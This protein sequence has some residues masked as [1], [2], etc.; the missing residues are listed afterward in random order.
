MR[1]PDWGAG[2]RNFTSLY[3]EPLSEPAI[4]E[5]LAGLV[6]GLPEPTI[7][8]VVARADGIP[9]YAVEIVRMLLAEGRVRE[10]GG[11]Y[12]PTGDIIRVLHPGDAHRA[13]RVAARR[14]GAGGPRPGPG[15][16][17]ARAELHARAACPR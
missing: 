6:P 1:R 2:K 16:G 7:R 15:R 3:L 8:A 11:R 12:V 17:G 9:L 4:R 10:E 5:L 13:H 14:P